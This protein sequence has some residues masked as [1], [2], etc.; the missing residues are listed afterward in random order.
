MI[1]AAGTGSGDDSGTREKTSSE[2]GKKTTTPVAAEGEGAVATSP[3]EKAGPSPPSAGKGEKT[4]P[5]P[6][7][8]GAAGIGAS[9]SGPAGGKDGDEKSDSSLTPHVDT[10]DL[11]LS[12]QTKILDEIKFPD[13][14]G[15]MFFV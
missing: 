7:T 5:T 6:P 9:H 13:K 10:E 14:N 15:G 8:G 3:G 4:G 2:D 12:N 11:R 1:S